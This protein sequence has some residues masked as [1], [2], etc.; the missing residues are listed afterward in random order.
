MNSQSRV[1]GVVGARSGSKSIPHKNIKPLLGKPLM[2]WIIEAAKR[3]P[4][5][6]RL[7]VSTDSTQYADISRKHGAESLFLRPAH[8]ADDKASDIDYL[9]HAVE[10]LEKN[11]NW[12]PDIILRLPP[13]TPLCTTESIN[14]CIQLLL[15]DPT[16]TSA[17]TIV[18]ASKHPYK[19]WRTEGDVLVPFIP[20]E[21]TG[22]SEP[23]NMPRQSLPPA[24]SHVDVIAVRYDTLMKDRLLTGP[25]VRYHK[26]NKLD[27][28][29]IDTEIDFLVAEQLLKRRLGL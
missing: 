24:F 22:H 19:L 20:K 16:A 23:S 11:E 26:L 18:T 6:T 28:V 14:A 1:L 12:K 17:R 25:R 15:D 10:W 3:S 13:T 5:V 27:A 9:T 4:L 21:M 2:A 7:I 29:D 8:L